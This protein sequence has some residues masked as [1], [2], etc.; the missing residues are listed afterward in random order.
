MIVQKR[1]GFINIYRQE[2]IAAYFFI[3]PFLLLFLIFQVIPILSAFAISFV[4][5]NKFIPSDKISSLQFVGFDNFKAV[6]TDPIA[7][8]SF[9]KSFIFSIIYVTLLIVF[10]LAIAIALN[11]DI[12]FRGFSRTMILMPYVSNIVSISIIFTVMFNPFG[13]PINELL[14]QMGITKPPMWLADSNMALPM[15]SLIA[16]WHS[17]AFQVIVLLAALQGVSKEMY[18]SADIDGANSW[19]QF[20]NITLPMISPT[21]FF[22][23]VTSLIRSFQNYDI[24]KNVTNGGPGAAS[25]VVAL[26]IY[27]EAF[28]L[29]HFSKSAAQAMILFAIVMIITVIQWKGQK[30][31]V[32]Y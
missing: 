28:N 5:F 20:L 32:H 31:W 29:N 12:F 27:D 3:A 19:Q 11:K 2:E 17:L 16:V 26:N 13:G 22:L 25:R 10:A 23:L 18:E 9:G 6:L 24:L 30:K 7:V 4:N 1:K 14:K 8:A 15:V 21:T